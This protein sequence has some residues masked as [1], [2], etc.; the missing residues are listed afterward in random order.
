MIFITSLCVILFHGSLFGSEHPFPAIRFYKVY[1][2]SGLKLEQ[3]RSLLNSNPDSAYRLANEVIFS[4]R[5]FGFYKETARAYSIKGE[6]SQRKGDFPNSVLYYLKAINLAEKNNWY[7]VLGSAYNGLGITFYMMQNLKQAE[8]YIRKA[9]DVKMKQKDYV[10]YAIIASN[11]AALLVF[12]EKNDEALSLLRTA[13]RVVQQANLPEYLP[14]IYNSI[15]AIFYQK[16]NAQDSA[17][18]YYEKSIQLAEKFDIQQN[19][20]TGYHNIGHLLLEKKQYEAALRYLRIGET[21]SGQ[22]NSAPMM[23]RIVQ[24]LAETYEAAGSA[25]LALKYR[26][27][28]LELSKEIFDSEKQKSIEELQLKYETAKKDI[29]YQEQ[30]RKLLETEL[31]AEK[32]TIRMQFLFFSALLLLIS[33]S[34]VYYFFYQ[35]RSNREKL[36]QVKIRIFENIVHDIRT[37]LTLIYGPLQELKSRNGISGDE[38]SYFSLIERNSEKLMRMVDELLDVSKIDQGKYQITWVNGNLLE[39]LK[40]LIK[41][42]EQEAKE[43]SI[44]LVS[45]FDIPSQHYRFSKDVLDKIVFNLISNAVKYTPKNTQVTVDARIKDSNFIL[46]V[47]D[48]GRGIEAKFQHRIFDR[49]FR[50]NEHENIPGTGI[51]L[52]VVKDFVELIGG[53]ICVESELGQGACFEVVFPIEQAVVHEF[54]TQSAANEKLHLMICDDDP[55]ILSFL[56]T[57]LASDYQIHTVNNGQLA[58]EY[59]ENNAPDVIL[60]DVMMPELDGIEL[61]EKL[62]NNQVWSSIPVVLFSAKSALES[63]LAGLQAG[64]DYYI[65]K[66][67]NLDELKLILRNIT[68]K[69][70]TN[71]DEFI[72]QKFDKAPFNERLKS[73]NEYV[74]KATNFVI[75]YID[76]SDYSVNEL[77]ADMCISRS[78]L[79]RKLT[80]YTGYSATQFIRMIRLEKAK[81]LLESN[82]GNVEEIAY[83]CGF[84]S[85]S[86]FSTVFTEYF[87]KPPSE[88]L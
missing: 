29:L 1:L 67:F 86:Y 57:V 8:I 17:L 72:R 20:I 12:E 4:A 15:G 30:A 77:A 69:I 43:K 22:M 65:S 40:E 82:A 32:A 3:S 58:L 84:S 23:L 44:N 56:R 49:F 52:A 75:Q 14:N 27:K 41:D 53:S 59:I 33:S 13:E 61:L 55:D 35:R 21:I 79:H 24:T 47:Q 54:T 60:S 87:G 73:D 62:K 10:Y 11:L 78:Q 9:L 74:N 88:F 63:R 36:N 2:S 7:D 66:P 45:S 85:R 48:Q 16:K 51:G 39:Y 18:F 64:A 50:L 42:F 25:N 19:V 71:R 38:R 37:P 81:D 68:S 31:R 5:Q 28:E 76:N 80:L 34:A 83:S 6:V 70:D 26:N 46:R